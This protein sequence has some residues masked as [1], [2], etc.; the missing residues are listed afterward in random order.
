MLLRDNTVT[1][2]EKAVIMLAFYADEIPL[3]T[4]DAIDH[5]IW[6]YRC[7]KPIET[8]APAGKAKAG[9]I[10]G[11]EQDANYIYA[12][13]LQAYGL[14]LLTTPLH[15]WVFCALLESLPDDTRLMQI[16]GYRATDTSK[17]KGE[18]KKRLENL[19]KVFALKSAPGKKLT[20]QERN[21]EMLRRERQRAEEI[22]RR[23]GQ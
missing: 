4:N 11:F 20:L 21:Q 1:D 19:K 13:F 18:E 5:I 7:G 22:V 17:L 10:Y 3:N 8:Q 14:N 12:A 6:F 23:A 2:E 9:Q 15:W 16:M